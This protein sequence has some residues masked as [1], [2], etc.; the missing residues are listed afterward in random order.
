MEVGEP[1]QQYNTIYED[2]VLAQAK[3]VIEHCE[4][5]GLPEQSNDTP[6]VLDTTSLLYYFFIAIYELIKGAFSCLRD[7]NGL[8]CMVLLRSILEHYVDM[9]LIFCLNNKKQNR[10]FQ[11][12]SLLCL[13]WQKENFTSEKAKSEADNI[14]FAYRRYAEKE[15]QKEYEEYL[16]KG[17]RKL[18]DK[19]PSFDKWLKSKYTKSWSALSLPDRIRRIKELEAA[20][21]IED[22]GVDPVFSMLSQYLHPTPWS[23][24]PHHSP[25][26]GEV[27][28]LWCPSTA[29]LR[30]RESHLQDV[31][32]MALNLFAKAVKKSYG[33]DLLESY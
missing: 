11:F 24:F 9:R 5:L 28:P 10:R 7:R 17:K 30:E 12:Y 2:K 13:F 1:T 33:H 6:P 14:E 15:F 29:F 26:T 22:L 32:Y 18:G 27:R 23:V 16:N 21:G 8:G 20:D 3:S 19:V 4:R 31:F 25:V